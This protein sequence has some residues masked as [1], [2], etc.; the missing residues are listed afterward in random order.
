MF[1]TAAATATRVRKAGKRTGREEDAAE[2]PPARGGSST[3]VKKNKQ[4]AACVLLEPP[5][6]EPAESVARELVSCDRLALHRLQALFRGSTVHRDG[7][8]GFG[9]DGTSRLSRRTRERLR[10]IGDAPNGLFLVPCG[11]LV[12]A[13]AEELEPDAQRRAELLARVTPLVE[14]HRVT[15]D[16]RGAV[17]ALRRMAA[18]SSQL[19]FAEADEQG[20]VF[21]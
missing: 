16:R 19:R 21:T 5:S 7:I 1:D 17:L 12:E 11:A 20:Q 14:G 8:E 15:Y 10:A 18:G 2:G 9:A 4:S 13:F 3:L 6:R